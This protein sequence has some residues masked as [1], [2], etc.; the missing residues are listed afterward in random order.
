[1]GIANRV[2]RPRP[3]RCAVLHLDGAPE[4]GHFG[5]NRWFLAVNLTGMQPG[6]LPVRGTSRDLR[7]RRAAMVGTSEGDADFVGFVASEWGRLARL[8]YLMCGDWQRAE[9]LVQ[10]V[11]VRIYPR[12]EHICEHG[13]PL[14]Y[15]RRALVNALID[16]KRKLWRRREETVAQV[17][18]SA[19]GELHSAQSSEWLTYVRSAAERLPARQ[20]AVI[21][22]RYVEDLT[23][24]EVAA[25]L[26]ISEGTVKSQAAR[27][28]DSLRR[29]LRNATPDPTSTL[30][31]KS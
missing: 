6:A 15:V 14:G 11:L 21:V 19:T 7:S 8:A 20:R 23:V 24:S 30:R 9:D 16:D 17:P 29:A 1:M 5:R 25:E 10:T 2:V 18:E 13:E 27:G 22:L 26:Q 12:W 3:P 31:R 4:T 28:L